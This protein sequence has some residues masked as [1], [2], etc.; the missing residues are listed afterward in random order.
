MAP[1]SRRK[2]LSLTGIGLSTALAGCTRSSETPTPASTATTTT[3][4]ET[5]TPTATATTTTE[6][7]TPET[8]EFQDGSAEPAPSCPDEYSSFNPRW[9][10]ENSGPLGGFNLTINQRTIGIGDTITVSLR[11]VTDSTQMTG[12]KQKYD[13]QY[14]DSN[15]W[16]TIFG[17]VDNYV[18]DDMG[19]GH[20]PDRGFTWQFSF[21]QE[22]LSNLSDNNGYVVCAP[23]N[24]GTYR[25]VYWGITTEQEKKEDYET[26]YALGIP[27]TVT[28][29]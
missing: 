11:N 29:N 1:P 3:G 15:G 25:F 21:S 12:N 8:T 9:I 16:H 20:E 2:F 23:I 17:V 10:V 26:D 14:R 13:V 7:Q 5:P 4:Q 24:P 6:Q 22:G 19:F 27:F 28:D 18:W